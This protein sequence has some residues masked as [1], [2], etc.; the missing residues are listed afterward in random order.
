MFQYISCCY[1]SA[2]VLAVRSAQ[3]FN[4]SHVVIYQVHHIKEVKYYPFQ[5]ISCCYLSQ[6]QYE[7]FHFLLLF[8]YISCCY[9]SQERILNQGK[10]YVS[11]HLMLLFIGEQTN[12]TSW[13]T[14]FN[15]SHVVIYLKL[16]KYW[17][18]WQQV[19]IHLML[20]FI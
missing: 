7:F 9:L 10:N 11:I 4:T 6:Q 2:F 20:L 3:R 19:S 5:Y 15:T 12:I 16:K 1:L 17:L 18:C 13:E 8:Q 14:C